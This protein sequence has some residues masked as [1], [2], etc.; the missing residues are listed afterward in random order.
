[1]KRPYDQHEHDLMIHNPD[2]YKWGSIY[3]NPRDSRVFVPKRKKNI[4]W[5]LNFAS[6]YTW[7]ILLVIVLLI[8]ILNFLK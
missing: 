2:N 6:P 5:T 7:V 1:M 3:Y 4:A 8:Y